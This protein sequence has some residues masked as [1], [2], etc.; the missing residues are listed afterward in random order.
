MN[1]GRG[2]G[3]RVERHFNGRFNRILRST[4]YRGLK[5]VVEKMT[6][7]VPILGKLLDGGNI[8]GFYLEVG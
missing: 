7:S 8:P 5:K 3:E 1:S 4:V 6:A 2:K